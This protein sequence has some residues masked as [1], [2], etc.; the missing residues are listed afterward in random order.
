MEAIFGCGSHLWPRDT[1]WLD[2]LTMTPRGSLVGSP[3]GHEKC[4]SEPKTVHVSEKLLFAHES[5]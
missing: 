1:R 4:P 3:L 2:R 5:H